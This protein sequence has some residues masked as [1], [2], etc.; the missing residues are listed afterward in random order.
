M[1]EIT[2]KAFQP[3]EEFIREWFKRRFKRDPEH[4]M[5]YFKEWKRRFNE[6]QGHPVTSYMDEDSRKH[7]DILIKERSE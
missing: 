4:D 7:L 2:K 1:T 3:T 5:G 6:Y